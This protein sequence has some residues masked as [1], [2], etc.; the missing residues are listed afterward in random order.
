MRRNG[1]RG[2][3]T[4]S[5]EAESKLKEG[6]CDWSAIPHHQGRGAVC[7]PLSLMPRLK[8]GEIAVE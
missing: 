2:Q 1:G 6:L 8:A 4:P 3:P 7:F 5:T